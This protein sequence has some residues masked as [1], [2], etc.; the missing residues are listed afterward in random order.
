M[1]A[2]IAQSAGK[3]LVLL[4]RPVGAAVGQ[5]P[6]CLIVV[7]I[8]IVYF[9][10]LSVNLEEVA[11]VLK[12]CDWVAFTSPTSLRLM[13][14]D[15]LQEIVALNR[16]GRIRVACVGPATCSEAERRGLAVGVMPQRYTTK[17]LAEEI[18]ATGASCVVAFRS[19]KASP[20]LERVLRERGVRVHT[21]PLYDLVP[22]ERLAKAAAASADYF[23]YVVF[24]SSTIAETFLK[25]YKG[26]FTFKAVAIGPVTAS[27]LRKLG[28]R[29]HIVASEHTMEGV[30][31]AL[32]DDMKGRC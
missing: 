9:K 17:S 1:E 15:L 32:I 28:V 22:L 11:K 3:G 27:A 19:S 14:K 2:S 7:H 18:A 6:H 21:V 13:P 26:P 24:T 23:D 29:V 5:H 25:Y 4:L 30:W 12:R 31:K 20:D 8:P 10:P 16:E